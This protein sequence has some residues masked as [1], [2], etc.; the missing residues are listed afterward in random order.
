MNA[1]LADAMIKMLLDK[2]DE[3]KAKAA[4]A[5][6]K[7]L[8]SKAAEFEHQF[9]VCVSV[10]KEMRNMEGRIRQCVRDVEAVSIEVSGDGPLS[11]TAWDG[12]A[13]S[14]SGLSIY[15]TVTVKLECGHISEGLVGN[16]VWPHSSSAHEGLSNIVAYRVKCRAKRDLGNSTWI[17]WEGDKEFPNHLCRHAIVRMRFDNGSVRTGCASEMVW[18]HALAP[19]NNGFGRITAYQIIQE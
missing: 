15:D 6:I 3:Y 7:F 10:E 8:A 18:L 4:E 9:H 13:A 19:S 5:A 1:E 16:L 2:A 11:W 12:G 14:P 17:N